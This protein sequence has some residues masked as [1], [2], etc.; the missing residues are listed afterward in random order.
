MNWQYQKKAAEDDVRRLSGV[1]GVM[2]NVTIKPHVKADDVK[3]KIEDALKRHAEVG[4]DSIRVTVRNDDQVVL[5]GKVD[6]WDE[7][8][9]VESAAWSAP[10]V[11]SVDDRILIGR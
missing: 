9:A 6:N 3:R 4:A 1:R 7:R 8:Y 2:N 5:E 10:G 11:K